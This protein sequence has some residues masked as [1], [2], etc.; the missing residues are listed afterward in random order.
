[1]FAG[2]R[3]AAEAGVKTTDESPEDTAV[4]PLSAFIPRS[5]S[6]LPLPAARLGRTGADSQHCL[7]PL[8]FNRLP[9]RLFSPLRKL[10]QRF[11]S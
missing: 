4:R 8:Y 10:S 9:P 1:M 6:S 7:L 11:R 2:K 5:T 3:T